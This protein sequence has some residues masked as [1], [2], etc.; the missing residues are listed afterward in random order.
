M[1][2]GSTPAT[3]VDATRAS[4]A[5]ASSASASPLAIARAAAPSLMPL[6]VPA[7]TVPSRMNAGVRR[8][9]PSS[10]TSARGGSS[11]AIVSTEPARRTSM[12]TVSSAKTPA[13]IAACARRW[14][15]TAKASCASRLMPCI[16]ATRSAV[17]PSEIVHSVFIRGF[18]NRHPI[19]ESASGGGVRSHGF[20]D[21]SMT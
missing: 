19:V 14:L 7:V 5:R 12:P 4:G 2:L 11:R 15:S 9:S 20:P 10:V 21:L 18:T 13:R 17:S 16:A 6:D 1:Q 8:A 3:A